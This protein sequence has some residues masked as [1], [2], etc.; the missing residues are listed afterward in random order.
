MYLMLQQP[1]PDDYVLATG[2]TVSVRAFV[3]WAF[4]AVGIQLTW[5]GDG[6]EEVGYGTNLTNPTGPK[7]PRVRI[8]AK[9]YRPT[10]VEKLLGDPGKAKRVLGWEASTQVE[11]LCKEM[12]EADLRL[13]RAGDLESRRRS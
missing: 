9:Y 4:R 2:K 12:V 3:E 11:Q 1:N 13:V 5:R 8:D 7:V 10:E 6:A